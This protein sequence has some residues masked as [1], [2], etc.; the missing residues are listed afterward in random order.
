MDKRMLL[1][2]LIL[3]VIATFFIGVH[4]GMN[5]FSKP[6]EAAELAQV[7]NKGVPTIKLEFPE[8]E[9]VDCFAYK[10]ISFSSWAEYYTTIGNHKFWKLK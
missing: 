6:V 7:F 3:L 5:G 8:H 10:T 2:L 9:E 4:I 1:L